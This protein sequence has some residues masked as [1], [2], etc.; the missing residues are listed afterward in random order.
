M[1]AEKGLFLVCRKTGK[2]VGFNRRCRWFRWYFPFVGVLALIWYLVRV[3][4][5][6][7]R[8]SYPCQKVGA[9]IAFGGMAYLLSILGLV[10]AFRKTRKFLNQHRYAAAGVCLAIGLVC[11]A[12]VQHMNESTARA[13]DTGTFT[14]SDGPNQP[15]GTAR[16]I[17][18]GR[19]AWGYDLSACTWDGSSSY[20]FSSTYNNQAKITKIMNNVVCSVAG[21][22]TVS[23]AWDVLFKFKNGGAAYVRGE[24]IAI[25]LNLNNGGN[26]DNQIDASPESVYALLDGLVNQFGANQADITLCDPARENQC[27]AI[28]DYCHTAFPNVIYDTNL[29][30]FK[31]SAFA[32]S[33]SGP[34]E[35]SL[36]TAIVNTKYLITMALLKRHCTPSATFGTDGVDYGNASVTMIF[37]SNWGI[38]GNNRASQHALL[39]DWNYP[40]ASYNQL[41]D[42]FGSK[43]I[44]GK[45]VLNILDGL[46]SGDRWNS[47]PHKWAMAP[48]NNHWPSSF[49][50]SQDPVALESVGLDFL[51]AEMPLIKNADRHLHEAALANNPPSG[52]VYQPDG[53]RLASLGVHEHWNNSTDKK[54][55]RNLGTGNGIELVTLMS[56]SWSVDITNPPGGA[57]FF[58]GTNITIQAGVSNATNPVARV[59]FYQGTLLLGTS[60]NSPYGITWSNVLSGSYALTAVATD[61]IGLSVTSSPVNITVNLL[62]NPGFELPGTGKIKTGYATIPGWTSSGITY[63]DTGVQAG[64]HSGSWE[65]YNQ[66]SDDGAYQIAGNYQIQMGD[67]FTLTWWS[68]G[69]WNGTSSS[70]AGTN[71]SDPFQTVTLLRAVA[72]NTAFSSTVRLALQTNGMPGGTWTPYTLTYTAG[73]ADA[74]KY[75]GVS[76][77]TAKNSGKTSGTWAAYDDFNLTVVSIPLAPGGLTASAGNGQVILNWNPVANAGGYYVRRSLVSG[78]SY[79]VIV[80]NLTSTIFTNTGLANGTTYYYVVSAFNQ[81]GAGTNSTEV[82]AL[83]TNMP[84]VIGWVVPTNNST[85]TQ[86]KTITLTVSATDADGTVTNVAFFN[87]TTLLG[88]VASGIGNQYSLTWNNAAV[89][90]YNL[91]ACATDNSGATNTSPATINLVVQPLTLTAS[92]MQTNGQ[93]CLTFRGQN[94]QNYVLETSTS[95]TMG[96]TPVWTSAP[97]NGVLSFTNVNATDGS[98]FYRVR[99]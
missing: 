33:V 22:S 20:W 2:I 82:S 51:R 80:T 24:K 79:T 32:Y 85:F 99:Q 34:T 56:G 40:M 28:Y 93:F 49:F 54:Y 71:A 58:Q 59:A 25:K 91:S 94:G 45:M 88:N 61:S 55:S 8:A 30:G 69:E 6:P 31:A 87:G 44:N 46:Y 81:A 41:V 76:F 60:T 68:Q 10:T 62:S 12:V 73:S 90:S 65:G 47:P 36:S 5:K 95:L 16:G 98:R 92:G 50:A 14:P 75:I 53:T 66:S 15:M 42:I 9:P 17:N 48:F 11:S 13:E 19:V 43:H 84:P 86:P 97:A 57:N 27:S 77:V 63:S 39:H 83:L 1:P 74:G 38:I 78:G 35:T 23:N 7:S 64:G 89:G 52:T 37:K 21:Q 18:P 96:W 3:I 4:P 70:Y 26:Y 72:T 67:Q 29:G